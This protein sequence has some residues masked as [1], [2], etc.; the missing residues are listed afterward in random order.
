MPPLLGLGDFIG[1]PF[2]NDSAP[3]ALFEML[4]T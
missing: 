3:T 1:Q 4:P 2:Y